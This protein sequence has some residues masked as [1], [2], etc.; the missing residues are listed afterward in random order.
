M[1]IP[2]DRAF[3]LVP[4][5]VLGAEWV[6]PC[7]VMDRER[8]ERRQGQWNSSG[9][10]VQYELTRIRTAAD[11]DARSAEIDALRAE[12][13]RLKAQLADARDADAALHDHITNGRRI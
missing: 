4:V 12:N 7:V 8:T 6:L 1:N 5:H 2:E 11:D 9:H 10:A 3:S 13:A